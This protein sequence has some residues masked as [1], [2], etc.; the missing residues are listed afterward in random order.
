M[1]NVSLRAVRGWDGNLFSIVES[2]LKQ[3]TR[4]V[5]IVQ[6]YDRALGVIFVKKIILDCYYIATGH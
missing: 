2:D 4:E 5:D 6:F 3:Q 1:S